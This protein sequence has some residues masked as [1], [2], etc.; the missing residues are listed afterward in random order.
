MKSPLLR[1]LRRKLCVTK[2]LPSKSRILSRRDKRLKQLSVGFAVMVFLRGNIYRMTACV[3]HSHWRVAGL[4][5][6]LRVFACPVISQAVW[7][8]LLFVRLLNYFCTHSAEVFWN[9]VYCHRIL[10]YVIPCF[11]AFLVHAYTS[12]LH[13]AM[14]PSLFKS[15]SSL[16]YRH[17]H[18]EGDALNTARL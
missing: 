2:A 6:R 4:R 1:S 13:L 11:R 8:A 3:V 10:S 7:R 9:A 15:D 12:G 5:T 14:P 17:F 16:F 18:R